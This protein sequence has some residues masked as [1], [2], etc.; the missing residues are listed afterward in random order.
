VLG[1]GDA[2]RQVILNLLTNAVDATPSGGR[3]SVATRLVE[4]SGEIE[5]VVGDTG[6]GIP[7]ADH[8]RIF[9]PF[10]S[11]KPTGRGTGLGLFITAQIVREHRGRIEVTS[12]EGQ[13]SV[14]R[15]RLPAVREVA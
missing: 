10:F 11:T 13:G 4:G 5:L 1:T 7:L 8:A 14:F 2:L 3:V 9:E 12:A 15:V 6:R